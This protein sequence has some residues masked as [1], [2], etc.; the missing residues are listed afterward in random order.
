[1]AHFKLYGAAADY[2]NCTDREVLNE[3][4]A[5]TGKT[6][7]ELVKAKHNCEKYPGSRGLFVRLTRASLT[8]TVLPDWEQKVLGPGHPAIGRA[9]RDNRSAYHF[10]NGSTVVL[11]GLDNPDRFLSAEFDWFI[12]FQAEEVSDQGAW[13]TLMSRLS[14]NAM[15]YVQATADANPSHER[16]WLIKRVEE[17]L[18]LRCSAIVERELQRCGKCGSTAIGRMRHHRFRH[19]DN[20][21]WFDHEK[22]ARGVPP[23][24]CWRPEGE[25]YL[26]GV[27]GRLRGP[28]RKR[29]LEHLWISE[30]GQVLDDWDPDIHR[31]SG[32]LDVDP[33][34]GWM[35]HVTAPGW[36][37]TTQDP[38]R[39]TPV[40]LRWFSAGADWG[41]F[42]HPGVFQVWGYDDAGRRFR[43][44]E[45]YK[46]EKQVEWW[47][48]RAEELW[49]EFD[50]QY[51]AVDP[52]AR[53]MIDA[54]NM[55]ISG[56]NQSERKAP[57]IAIGADN[58]IRREG[59]DFAGI[60]LM[61]WG[62]K[63]PNGIVRTFFLRDALRYG[64]DEKLK[65]AARPTCTEEEVAEWVFA[66]EAS[67]G[68]TLDKPDKR[69]D[70]HGLDAWR[71]EAAEGWGRRMAATLEAQQKYPDGT[72]GQIL[73][74]DE[75]MRKARQAREDGG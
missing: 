39:R 65:D 50:L 58:T 41:F 15:P 74:H 10:P 37:T 24:L 43:V 55:R 61:R 72:M 54:F 31:I 48:E 18:C 6:H 45:I 21:R 22:L 3:S 63:D 4:G 33:R 75:K 19:H 56:F 30:E 64:V 60:D 69:C 25:S 66:K 29:L 42:P 70:D 47:A 36:S 20:P 2:F 8:E 57:G 27:L 12:L 35:L 62:L 28:K 34:H 68:R 9:R 16:H 52:S 71:Y 7:S 49:R 38:M 26:L 32:H 51:I 17:A 1:M 73:R 46:T 40:K 23:H 13:D 59:D 5:R 53:A 14:G 44:V 67:T 11:G